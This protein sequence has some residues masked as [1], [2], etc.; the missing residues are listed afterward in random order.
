MAVFEPSHVYTHHHL[1]PYLQSIIMIKVYLGR[2]PL[3]N[4]MSLLSCSP[5]RSLF[6]VEKMMRS[7]ITMLRQVGRTAAVSTR[8]QPT[9]CIRCM[10]SLQGRYTPKID[11]RTSYAY[12]KMPVQ[13]SSYVLFMFLFYLQDSFI[14]F[15]HT[16]SNPSQL[17]RESE[18]KR[19]SQ[20]IANWSLG[21]DIFMTT[22]KGAVGW[23]LNSSAILA[24]ISFV[25]HNCCL[26]N[27][28]RRTLPLF[29]D[30]RCCNTWL[31]YNLQKTS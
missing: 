11:K 5:F 4:P 1:F 28:L 31:R 20:K 30:C 15:K 18:Q 9:V 6:S 19:E 29:Y 26:F 12:S 7:G 17:D 21:V 23:M 24:D 13:F 25:L 10:S 8:F 14:R 3:Y 27:R 22:V 2:H 16:N